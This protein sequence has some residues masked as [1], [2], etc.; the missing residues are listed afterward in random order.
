MNK[1]SRSF[2]LRTKLILAFLLTSALIFVVNL[3]LF[4]NINRAINRIDAVYD[5]NRQITELSTSL[6]SVHTKLT[7][8]L[9]T[10]STAALGDFYKAEGDFRESI[11][12]LELTDEDEKTTF[13]LADIA[14]ISEHYLKLC[15]TAVTSKRGRDIRQ[16]REAYTNASELYGYLEEYIYSINNRMLLDNSDSYAKLRQSY[17]SLELISMFVLTVVT[18]IN[19]LLILL[20]VQSS[21]RPLNRLAELAG[22][23]SKGNFDVP[24]IDIVSN[25][26]IGI[27]TAAFNEMVVSI[28]GYIQQLRE[29][30][31]LENRMKEKELL[32]NSHLKEAELKYLQA[33]IN[34][35]FLFNTLNAGAQLSMMEDADR[36]Y[37]YLQNVAAFFRTKTNR[38]NQV[39]TLADEVALVDSYIYIINVRF[40]GAIAYE[41]NIDEDL[42]NVSVPSMI[43]QPIIENAVNHGV[44]DID[45]P[46]RIVLSVYRTGDSIT[47]SVKDN[48]RGMNEEQIRALLAG[49]IRP[50]QKGDETNGVG[51]G[52]VVNRLK[53]FYDSEDVFDVTSAGEG[54]GTE[55]LLYIP[56][57]E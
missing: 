2:S 22:E 31:E 6:S 51:L 55:V 20:L 49:E 19:L 56:M 43:L 54:K 25:D 30:M 1:K 42:V 48:G 32:M 12:Y 11:Y 18:G 15:E 23:V 29:S 14:S 46:A 57:P 4:L 16:Y 40:S 44:R 39:M 24:A 50:R 3:F 47:I 13:M 38:D 27:V 10:K 21:T 28:R 36:T 34:P 17:R 26:E 7:E 41:K 5:S 8:Y 45:W 35:H 37:R 53:L 9:N 52:N 33:Q